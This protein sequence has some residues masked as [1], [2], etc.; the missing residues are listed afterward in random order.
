MVVPAGFSSPLPRIILVL[1]LALAATPAWAIS[2]QVKILTPD[3]HMPLLG[4]VK[5]SFSVLGIQP[6]GIAGAD[7]FLDGR[8][9]ASVEHPPWEAIIDAGEELKPQKLELVVRLRNGGSLRQSRV[10]QPS[11]LA[12][13]S[14]RMVNLAVSVMDSSDRPLSGLKAED[15][16][17]LDN[18][19]PVKVERFRSGESPLAVALVFDMSR[20]MLGEK[21]AAAKQAAEAFLSSLRSR[22]QVMV[23]A[24]SDA[25]HLVHP[26]GHDHA[27]AL[28]A[29]RRLEAG[30][31]TALYDSVAAASDILGSAPAD[32]RRV[33]LV[34]SDGRDEAATGLGPG[35]KH[36]LDK[37]IH[38][39]HNK[40]VV[41][42]SVGLGVGLDREKDFTKTLTTAEVL[43]RLSRS[44]GGTYQRVASSSRLERAFSRVTEELRRQYDLAFTPPPAQPGESWRNLKVVVQKSGAK[45]RAREGYFVN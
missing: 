37:A 30:G 40:D 17:I 34:L 43:Q 2:P 16:R 36:T 8:R 1:A 38:E 5:V 14:V 28:E 26:L 35:S 13:V 32:F 23:L 7:L 20:T 31:G 27:G 33:A 25:P 11:G 45:T 3:P 42:F 39:A 22:D 9:L 18:G 44:T 15:F 10:Q 29:V 21:I 41:L 19:Q 4:Q 6:E 24:F 12:E